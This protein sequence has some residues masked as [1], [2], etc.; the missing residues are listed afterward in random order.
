MNYILSPT[1]FV[2]LNYT[3]AMSAS[4]DADYSARFSNPSD[5]QTTTGLAHLDTSQRVTSQAFTV[6]INKIF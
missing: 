1:W 3:F 6:S 2:D 5:G 4:F